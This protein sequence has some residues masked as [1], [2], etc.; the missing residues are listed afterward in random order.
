MWIEI[1]DEYLKTLKPYAKRKIRIPKARLSGQWAY[2]HKY[3]GCFFWNSG[4]DAVYMDEKE[5]RPA[6]VWRANK[7]LQSDASPRGAG[8]PEKS[9]GSR[10]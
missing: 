7:R 1:T 4:E 10:R 5:N 3:E 6:Y 8:K 9:K 2:W